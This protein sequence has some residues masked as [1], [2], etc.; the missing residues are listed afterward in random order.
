[1]LLHKGDSTRWPRF[2]LAWDSDLVVVVAVAAAVAAV[3]L[4]RGRI[5]EKTATRVKTGW[6]S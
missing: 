6:A 4:V 2:S 3:S 1:M 5:P